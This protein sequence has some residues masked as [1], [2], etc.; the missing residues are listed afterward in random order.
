MANVSPLQAL[1]ALYACGKRCRGLVES[2]PGSLATQGPS[3]PQPDPVL[4]VA[5]SNLATFCMAL[6]QNLATHGGFRHLEIRKGGDRLKE[7]P[8]VWRMCAILDLIA[9]VMVFLSRKN[10]QDHVQ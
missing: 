4:D 8:S 1:I 7:V 3:R 10:G 5:P 6:L 9:L 2:P